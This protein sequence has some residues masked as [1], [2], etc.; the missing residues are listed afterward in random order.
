MGQSHQCIGKCMPPYTEYATIWLGQATRVMRD[1]YPTDTGL[2]EAPRRR[3]KTWDAGTRLENKTQNRIHEPR[4]RHTT[5]EHDPGTSCVSEYLTP[6]GCVITLIKY[7][8]YVSGV[9]DLVNA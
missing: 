7:E 5:R 3:N 4:T 8:G 2:G 6:K 9:W 1:A